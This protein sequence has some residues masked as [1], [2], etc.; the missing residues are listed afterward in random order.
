MID[1][2]KVKAGLS[3]CMVSMND[4][5]PF[6]KCADCPY[7]DESIYVDDCRAVLSRDDL[8]VIESAEV[9]CDRNGT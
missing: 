1:K 5:D 4:E 6:G 9:Q 3:C 7:N 8:E 2:A